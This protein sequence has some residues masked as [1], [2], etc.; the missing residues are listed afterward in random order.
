MHPLER[1]H[2][3]RADIAKR[4]VLLVGGGTIIVVAVVLAVAPL[5]RKP[6]AP[7]ASAVSQTILISMAGFSPARLRVPANQAITLTVVN[8]DSRFHTDGGWHQFAID[9]LRVDVRVEPRAQKT[10]TLGPLAPGVYEFYCDIC[11]G[12]RANPSM[13]GRLEVAG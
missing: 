12:G 7:P 2:G 8:P 6:A 9:T 5:R 13:V 11:C 1:R 4:L 10:V 3:E